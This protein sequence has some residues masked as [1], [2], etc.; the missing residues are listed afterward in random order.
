ME[1]NKKTI[2]VVKF[3]TNGKLMKLLGIIFPYPDTKGG[4]SGDER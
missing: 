1:D 4:V 3:N 2:T